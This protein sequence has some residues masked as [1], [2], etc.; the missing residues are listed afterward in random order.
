MSSTTFTCS[1]EF[2]CWLLK[3]T[4]VVNGGICTPG[5]SSGDDDLSVQ[6]T[7]ALSSA[8]A[9]IHLF[10]LPSPS[11]WILEGCRACLPKGWSPRSLRDAVLLYGVRCA[12][13][14]PE[15]FV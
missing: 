15:S 5:G 12:L 10:L 7:S 6:Q 13:P 3:Q 14:H 2:L 8:L 4:S 9:D 11:Y 1:V